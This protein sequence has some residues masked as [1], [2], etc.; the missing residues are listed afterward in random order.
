MDDTSLIKASEMCVAQVVDGETVLL[1]L[2]QGAYFGLDT[3]GSLIWHHI[4][5]GATVAMILAALSEKYP[6]VGESR[7]RGDLEALL[8]ELKDSDLIAVG[9]APQ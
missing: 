7:L 1:H 9:D 5:S 8:A 6:A 4:E 2:A 3:T